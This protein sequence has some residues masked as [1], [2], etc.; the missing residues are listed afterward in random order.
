MCRMAFEWV[1]TCQ[2]VNIKSLGKIRIKPIQK[3]A[4]FVHPTLIPILPIFLGE[5]RSIH[6]FTDKCQLGSGSADDLSLASCLGMMD[7]NQ[8]E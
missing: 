5:K 1:W 8:S 6:T 2:E 7:G 4:S 3:G